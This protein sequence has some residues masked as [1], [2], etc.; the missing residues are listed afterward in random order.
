VL[1]FFGT[2]AY[3]WMLSGIWLN[4]FKKATAKKATTA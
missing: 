2:W 1:I 4:Y 3:A